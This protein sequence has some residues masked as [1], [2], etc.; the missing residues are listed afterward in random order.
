LGAGFLDL[1]QVREIRFSP[2]GKNTFDRFDSMVAHRDLFLDAGSYFTEPLHN[3]GTVGVPVPAGRPAG[4]QGPVWLLRLRRERF[5]GVAV[6]GDDPA[7]QNACVLEEDPMGKFG[8][9]VSIGR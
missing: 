4:K 9:D 3:H 5:Q 7:G 2:Y 1:E 8:M 6:E